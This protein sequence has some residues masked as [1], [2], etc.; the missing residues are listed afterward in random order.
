[1]WNTCFCRWLSKEIVQINFLCPNILTRPTG[2]WVI[3][4]VQGILL[5]ISKEATKVPHTYRVVVGSPGLSNAMNTVRTVIGLS[6][7]LYLHD[8]ASDILVTLPSDDVAQWIT[9][10]AYNFPS[11]LLCA[12]DI[13]QCLLY[14]PLFCCSAAHGY[15]LEAI[16]GLLHVSDARSGPKL[17]A[18]REITQSPNGS[19]S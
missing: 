12:C 11:P 17:T 13:S 2:P 15:D 16:V 19:L 7:W 1:M 6:T 4:C 5:Q 14:R 3:G 18:E 9:A 10:I 8:Y